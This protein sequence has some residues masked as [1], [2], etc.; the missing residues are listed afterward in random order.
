MDEALDYLEERQVL[1]VL[2][3]SGVSR[4]RQTRPATC[5][6]GRGPRKGR[7]GPAWASSLR[8]VLSMWP[9]THQRQVGDPQQTATLE[10][11]SCTFPPTPNPLWPDTQTAEQWRVCRL[12]MTTRCEFH[13]H[14][15]LRSLFERR[16][17]RVTLFCISSSLLRAPSSVPADERR[18]SLCPCF[19]A[20][21]AV[22]ISSKSLGVK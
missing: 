19:V 17:I 5:E 18:G 7:V 9:T 22:G 21:A 4:S 16:I 14:Y 11:L 12:C 8:P 10:F 15:F 2:F 3:H 13:F 1:C 6:P 20:S